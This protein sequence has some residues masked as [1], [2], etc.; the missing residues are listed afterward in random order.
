[1]KNQ[2]FRY[3]I[4]KSSTQNYQEFKIKYIF[5]KITKNKDPCIFDNYFI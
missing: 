1:M 2:E 5:K 3:F 4:T